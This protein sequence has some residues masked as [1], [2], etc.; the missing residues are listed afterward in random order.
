MEIRATYDEEAN[1]NWK[2]KLEEEGVTVYAGTPNLKIHTKICIIKKVIDNKTIRYGFIATGN[3][4]E[5]TALVY[6]D[7]FFLTSNRKIMKDINRVFKALEDSSIDWEKL[8]SCKSLL[9]SPQT[10]RSEL[11]SMIDREIKNKLNGKRAGI[12]LQLNAL[13]DVEMIEKL[14]EAAR[15]GVEI[16]MVVRSI[17]CAIPNQKSFKKP[18]CATSIV[19]EFLEHGRLLVFENNGAKETF[20]TSA[21]WM[22]RNLDYRLEIAVRILDPAIKK[23]LLDILTIKFDDNVKARILDNQSSNHYSKNGK[24][25]VRAQLDIYRYLHNLAHAK[26]TS[27]QGK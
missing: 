19:D 15:A 4:N 16:R 2:N 14:Y 13:S 27:R 21:D 8:K 20:I 10:M 5:E 18:L 24:K 1:L 3:L 9:L 17:M 12:K 6:A 22:A 25:K 7:Y 11:I 26:P 23:Q